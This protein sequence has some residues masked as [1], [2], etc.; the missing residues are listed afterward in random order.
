MHDRDVDW[1][2][3][4]PILIYYSYNH[5]QVSDLKTS[6]QKETVQQASL[7]QYDMNDD[8]ELGVYKLG[9]CT[10][11]SSKHTENFQSYYKEI[12]IHAPATWVNT[13]CQLELV[14]AQFS[15]HISRLKG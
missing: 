6:F 12:W 14:P 3:L 9:E 1:Y 15:S 10:T 7:R 8:C 4:C 2:W 5:C 11:A 13:V